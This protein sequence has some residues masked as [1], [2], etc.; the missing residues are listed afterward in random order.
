[1]ALLI[2]TLLHGKS[3]PLLIE[4]SSLRHGFL[5]HRDLSSNADCGSVAFASLQIFV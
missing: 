1:M 2:L 5:H 4:M 3:P